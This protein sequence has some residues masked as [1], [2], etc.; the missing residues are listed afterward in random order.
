M[1]GVSMPYAPFPDCPP[2][3]PRDSEGDLNGET[4][5]SDYLAGGNRAPGQYARGPNRYLEGPQTPTRTRDAT[6]EMTPEYLYE[7]FT[8]MAA[9]MSDFTSLIE[10]TSHRID[11][12]SNQGTVVENVTTIQTFPDYDAFPI[13]VT[14]VLVTGPSNAAGTA[15]TLQLGKR[16]WQL[17]LPVTGIIPIAPV[18]FSMNPQDPRVLTSATAGNW[19]MEIMGHADIR[20]R[21]K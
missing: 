21:Y 13:I 9:S 10:D 5:E 17:V 8:R 7:V 11:E 3:C 19:A 4:V 12:F 6:P 16:N 1:V 20:Y 2:N 15:F 18:Y 14:S